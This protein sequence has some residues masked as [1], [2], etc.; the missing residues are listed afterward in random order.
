MSTPQGMALT[1][2]G[3]PATEFSEVTEL[4]GS[5]ITAEQLTRMSHRYSWA[6]QHCRQKDVVEVACGSGQGLGM[7]GSVASS[8]EAGD[9]TE[10][11]L[12]IARAHYGARFPLARLDAQALPY[13]DA[14][15]DVVVLFEAIYYIPDATRFARECRRILRPGGQVLIATANKDLYDFNPSPLSHRYYGTEELAALFRDAGFEARLFGYMPIGEASLLQR[16]LRPAK[17]LAV[18]LRLMPTS[19]KGKRLLKRLVFGRLVPMPAELPAPAGELEPPVPVAADAPDRRHKV[20][21][22]CATLPA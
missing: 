14:S 6:A 3:S 9:Y 1:I 4:A 12:R 18:A 15:K 13:A 5:R 16:V 21:Y 22:C 11:I 10:S 7:L 2:E 17:K 19:L 20:L 8:L